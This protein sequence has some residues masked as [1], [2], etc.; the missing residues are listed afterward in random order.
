ME[1][2]LTQQSKSLLPITALGVA[3]VI[4]VS[5]LLF[6]NVIDMGTSNNLA[7]IPQYDSQIKASIVDIQFSEANELYKGSILDYKGYLVSYQ[8]TVDGNSFSKTEMIRL[9]QKDDIVQ[10]KA[11]LENAANSLWIQVDSN[12][13]K[14]SKIDFSKSIVSF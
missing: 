1:T 6:F 10:V 7:S 8:Y 14:T 9:G 3:A 2:T 12:N 11:M 5:A 13:P 4:C